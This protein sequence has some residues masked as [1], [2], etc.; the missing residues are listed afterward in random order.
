MGVRCRVVDSVVYELW[1]V[2]VLELVVIILEFLLMS[3]CQ[4]CSWCLML[5][6]L[7]ALRV[8]IAVSGVGGDRVGGSGSCCAGGCCGGFEVG[9]CVGVA[10]GLGA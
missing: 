4:C 5:L 7:L 9:D 6:F 10:G 1:N 8:K 3:C 2:S